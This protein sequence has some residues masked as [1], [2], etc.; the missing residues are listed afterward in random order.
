M[1]ALLA[2]FAFGAITATVAQAATEGPLWTVE[3][4]TLKANETVELTIKAVGSITLEAT[5]LGIKAKVI[6]PSARVA[7]GGY[8]AGGSPGTSREI[9]EFYGGCSLTNIGKPGEPCTVEEPIKTEPIRNELV[10]SDGPPAGTF[11]PYLLIEFKPE[12]GTKFV[13]LHFIGS[14]CLVTETEVTGEVLGELY[15]D[16]VVDS[17][18]E[19]KV[20]TG[21]PRS[22]TSYLVVFPHE[23]ESIWLLKNVSGTSFW[24]LVK[25]GNLKAFGNT[26]KLFG[27]VLVLL[28]N[29]KK[30]GSEL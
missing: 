1:M 28:V 30:Y 9:P 11:G 26:A 18:I 13:T 12:N 10:V 24:E 20:T 27:Q 21:N 3:G 2:V 29:G 7:K 16:P 22:L 4:K 19:E 5:L 14:G 25:P 8:L 6:C 17:G 23:P 15:T